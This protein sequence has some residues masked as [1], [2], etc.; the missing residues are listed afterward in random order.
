MS[1][2]YLKLKNYYDVCVLAVF[3]YK[4]NKNDVGIKINR[5]TAIRP[6]MLTSID[7]LKVIFIQKYAKNNQVVFFINFLLNFLEI[8]FN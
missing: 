1:I 3:T 7:C 6:R 8:N 2:N 5:A 4:I